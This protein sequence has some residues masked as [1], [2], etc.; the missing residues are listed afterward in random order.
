M[1]AMKNVDDI[2]ALTPMQELMLT[3][4]VTASGRDVLANQVSYEIRGDLDTELFRVAWSTLTERHPALRTAILWEGLPQPVQVVRSRVEVP[5]V[6]HDLSSLDSADRDARVQEISTADRGKGFDLASAPLYRCTLVRTDA[7]GFVFMWTVHH[8]VVDRWSHATLF[9]E[10]AEVYEALRRDEEPTLP[11]PVPFRQYVGW[12][13]EQSVREADEYWS[14]ALRGSGS[15]SLIGTAEAQAGGLSEERVTSRV[16]ISVGEFEALKGR[17]AQWRTTVGSL[18]LGAVGVVLARRSGRSDVVYGLTVSGRPTGLSGVERAVGSFVNNVP[19]RVRWD[20]EAPWAHALA[21]IQRQQVERHPFEYVSPARIVEMAGLPLGTPLFDVL[22]VPN[23]EDHDQAEWSSIEMTARDA[24]FDASFP[25]VLGTEIREGQLVLTVV[26]DR[27]ADGTAVAGEVVEVLTEL[28]RV[29]LDATVSTLVPEPRR[30]APVANFGPDATVDGEGGSA[31]PV[32]SIPDAV[33]RVWGSV[34]GLDATDESQDFF[35]LGG[36]S[37][38]AVHILNGVERLTG[39]RLGIAGL[40]EAK[41]LGALIERVDVDGSGSPNRTIPTLDERA[42]RPL[43]F[44]Q[45]R[46]WVLDRIEGPS[47]VYNLAFAHRLTG[48]VEL[49]VLR[50]SIDEVVR[51]HEVLAVVYRDGPGGPRQHSTGAA[52]APWDWSTVLEPSADVDVLARVE[53]WVAEPFDLENGPLLRVAI[54]RLEPDEH[55]LAVVVHHSLADAWSVR[56]FSEDL[57]SAYAALSSEGQPAFPPLP[58]Q[59]SDFA[60]WQRG[61]ANDDVFA[62]QLAY[63]GERLADVQPLDLPTDRARPPVQSFR[64]AIRRVAL[65][66]ELTDRLKELARSEGTTLFNVLMAAFHVLLH[67]YSGQT[68][69]VVGTPFA[70]R[71]HPDVDRLIGMFVNTILIRTAPDP[72]QTFRSLLQGVTADSTGAQQHQELPFERLVEALQPAR[73]LS[74]NPLFQVMFALQDRRV[75]SLTLPGVDVRPFELAQDTSKF[76]LTLYMQEAEEGSAGL[77]GIW[78]YATDL[79]D[80]GTIERMQDHFVN[81]LRHLVDDP[82]VSLAD[83]RLVG[84]TERRALV[85]A[86]AGDSTEEPLFV[87]GF[88][89]QVARSPDRVAVVHGDVETTYRELDRRSDDLAARLVQEGVGAERTVGICLHRSAD[90]VVA[91]LGVLKSGG[92]Y[93]PLDPDYPPERLRYMLED[94]GATLLLTSTELRTAL[95]SYRGH[96][97][98]VDELETGGA[99]AAPDVTIER[100]QLASARP[101]APSVLWKSRREISPLIRS[102]TRRVAFDFLYIRNL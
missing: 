71:T 79:F 45:E 36:S 12:V 102:S 35:A 85:G 5:W 16:S 87:D 46:L 33:R 68:D 22:V 31:D 7:R 72:E 61:E 54:H 59:Y 75:A 53:E 73:D 25:Y 57:S 41:T 9:A 20:R 99:S 27:G 10:L 8:L 18:L 14:A 24:T 100:D 37:I 52:N 6:E 97:V 91:L 4:T 90:L 58:I 50:Q 76:D 67:R 44:A 92:A 51:R 93:V 2:F 11:P 30:D 95:P 78:E 101:A 34:L 1:S 62:E 21:E 15:P 84:E 56:V 82:D 39:R 64:G 88:R 80:G 43:S 42:P 69:V 94:T 49:E 60:S 29:A 86:P 63:W 96:V 66:A 55:V 77:E 83:A 65:G 70:G 26:H 28:A 48:E 13:S 40:F 3:S 23:F 17:A 38:Q 47:S 74:R 89:E 98:L 19:S 32:R 81:L